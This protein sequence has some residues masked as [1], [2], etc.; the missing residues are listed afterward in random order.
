MISA[1]DLP[2]IIKKPCILTARLLPGVRIDDAFISIERDGEVADGRFSRDRFRYY[3]DA[4]GIEHTDNDLQSSVMGCSLQEMLS[5]LLSFLSA[6][7]ES[8]NF[9]SRTGHQGEN[10]DLFPPSIGQWAAEHSDELAMLQ[11][12][13]DETPDLIEE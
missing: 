10:A 9:A 6:C 12:E 2:M 7:G 3:F 1:K 8:V 5:T 11:C 13:L 4:P